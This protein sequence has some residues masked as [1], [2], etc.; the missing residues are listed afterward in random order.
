MKEIKSID[1]TWMNNGAHFP[2]IAYVNTEIDHYRAEVISHPKTQ[3]G[4]AA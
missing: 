4:G 3:D 2:F 1:L